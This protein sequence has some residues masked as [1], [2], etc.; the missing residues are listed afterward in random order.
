MQ[1]TPDCKHWPNQYNIIPKL[2]TMTHQTI[3]FLICE[4]AVFFQWQ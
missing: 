4:P 1:R 2:Y 3:S